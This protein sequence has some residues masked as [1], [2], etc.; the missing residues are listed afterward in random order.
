MIA[1]VGFI[2]MVLFGLFVFLVVAFV[3]KWTNTR[4]VDEL[5]DEEEERA[6]LVFA[7]NYDIDSSY[8]IE[9]VHVYY[10][11]DEVSGVRFVSYVLVSPEKDCVGWVRVSPCG[12]MEVSRVGESGFGFY[13]KTDVDMIVDEFPA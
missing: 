4:V 9:K 7:F 8:L 5:V 1:I 13:S 3:V 12:D 10:P 6:K 11:V 2:A